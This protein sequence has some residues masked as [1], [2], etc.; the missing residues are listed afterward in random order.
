MATISVAV[1][2]P[3]CEDFHDCVADYCGLKIPIAGHIP[4]KWCKDS[5]RFFEITVTVVTVIVVTV[6]TLVN[7]SFRFCLNLR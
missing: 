4:P 5:L 1:N 3:S 7:V 2:L 6:L